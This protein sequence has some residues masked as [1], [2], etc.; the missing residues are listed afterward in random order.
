MTALDPAEPA[1]PRLRAAARALDASSDL[2]R[3]EL[4]GLRAGIVRSCN[5]GIVGASGTVVGETKNMLVL[6]ARDSGRGGGGQNCG[7]NGG[8]GIAARGTGRA[9]RICGLRGMRRPYRSY[10][11]AGSVWRFEAAGTA[12]GTAAEIDGS[13][14]ARR[15]EDRLRA[16]LPPAAAA[17]GR[18]RGGAGA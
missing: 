14:I 12:A 10:P 13:L 3:G 15:P 4:V 16:R 17:R 11:K 2:H 7:I 5:P 9:E 6:S 1:R 8:A 18:Q